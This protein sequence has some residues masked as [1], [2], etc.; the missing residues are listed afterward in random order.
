MAGLCEGGNEPPGSLKASKLKSIPL[1]NY[2]YAYRST[3]PMEKLPRQYGAALIR[4]RTNYCTFYHTIMSY[5]AK[6]WMLTK[7]QRRRIEAAEMRLLRPLAGYRLKDQNR[8]SEIREELQILNL[9]G[10][11]S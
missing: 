5:G 6:N 1:Q 2:E 4:F 11:T 9:L 10:L 8:N 7:Q 3:D